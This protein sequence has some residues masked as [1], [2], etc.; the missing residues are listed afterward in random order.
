MT[1]NS[2]NRHYWLTLLRPWLD[3]MPSMDP[4]EFLQDL[5]LYK[6]DM[7]TD[8]ALFLVQEFEL[9]LD[10]PDRIGPGFPEMNEACSGLLWQVLHQ[11][12]ED[13]QVGP[14]VADLVARRLVKHGIPKNPIF[15]RKIDEATW[16]IS[17][18]PPDEVEDNP[19]LEGGMARRWAITEVESHDQSTIF[20]A[21]RL[22]GI[23]SFN[24]WKEVVVK[25]KKTG[26]LTRNEGLFG[27]H[28]LPPA[29]NVYGWVFEIRP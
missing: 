19:F 20:R 7:L 1:Q 21:M 25:I 3:L 2:T 10:I 16:F 27:A 12:H 23:L 13:P 11:L 9:H 4:W 5:G 18:E 15:L 22:G 8:V 14:R 6:D 28:W 24:D 26:I 29:D 17:I